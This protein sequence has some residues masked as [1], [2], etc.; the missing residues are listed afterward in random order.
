VSQL[1]RPRLP[2]LGVGHSVEPIDALKA[3]LGHQ[4]HLQDLAADMISAAES[5]LAAHLDTEIAWSTA[6][7]DS[8]LDGQLPDAQL[9]LL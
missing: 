2:E 8:D 4:T 5:L 3:Y 1:A 6:A 7:T 9:R